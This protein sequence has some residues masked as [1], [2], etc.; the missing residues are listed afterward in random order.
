MGV[1]KSRLSQNIARRSIIRKKIYDLND[2][3][4]ERLQYSHDVHRTLFQGNFS[5]PVTETLQTGAKV[6]DFRYVNYYRIF[7]FF[8]TYSNLFV[9]FSFDLKD[10]ALEHGLAKCQ[11]ISETPNFTQ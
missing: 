4:V 1:S 7:F 10:A 6:L 5:S 11:A 2:L 3:E 8:S 9:L